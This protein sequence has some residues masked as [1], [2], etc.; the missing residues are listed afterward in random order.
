[1][2]SPARK[3]NEREHRGRQ[4]QQVEQQV[5]AQGQGGADNEKGTPSKV[6]A[7]WFVCGSFQLHVGVVCVGAFWFAYVWFQLHIE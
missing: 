5:G 4:Q 6:S 7:Y 3:P 1:M 2:A